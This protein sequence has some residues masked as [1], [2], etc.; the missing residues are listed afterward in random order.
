[1]ARKSKTLL[2]LLLFTSLTLT[3]DFFHSHT[4]FAGVSSSVQDELMVQSDGSA[5]FAPYCLVCLLVRGYAPIPACADVK[6]H[7]VFEFAKPIDSH[8]IYFTV[9]FTLPIYRAPPV[10]KLS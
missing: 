10:L 3:Q 4:G 8:F 7:G 5:S 1:M 2:L 6:V 9:E